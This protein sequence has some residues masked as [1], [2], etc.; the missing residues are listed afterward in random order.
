MAASGGPQ[1]LS[2]PIAEFLAIKGLNRVQGDQA[3]REEWAEIAGPK[4]ASQTRIRRLNRAVLHVEVANAPLMGELASFHKN[5]LLKAL[6][7]RYGKRKI[8]DLK[9]TLNSSLSEF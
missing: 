5:A 3:L 6:Q 8:R 7:E 4:I 2:E 1:H 9:L